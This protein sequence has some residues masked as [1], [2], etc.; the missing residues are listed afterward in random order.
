[1]RT[2]H[3]KTINELPRA[4][5]MVLYHAPYFKVVKEDGQSDEDHGI[6]CSTYEY[7]QRYGEPGTVYI[8]RSWI[9][10]VKEE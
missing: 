2:E 4:T 5:L 1:M 6:A 3:I 7:R 8:L 10:I 9:F